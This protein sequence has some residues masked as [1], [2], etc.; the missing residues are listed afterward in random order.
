MLANTEALNSSFRYLDDLLNIDNNVHIL[1][2]WFIKFAL[3]EIKLNKAIIF[4]TCAPLQIINIYDKRDFRWRC[5]TGYVIWDIHTGSLKSLK[6]LQITKWMHKY[7]F[8]SLLGQPV[9]Y[10]NQLSNSRE[11]IRF[12]RASSHA[13]DFISYNKHLPAKCLKQGYSVL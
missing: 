10:S 1:S 5:L 3:K 12:T 2:K 13:S 8:I 4:Y 6:M 11:I 7:H 9:S